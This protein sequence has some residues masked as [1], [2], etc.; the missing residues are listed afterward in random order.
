MKKSI[1]LI[2]LIIVLVSRITWGQTSKEWFA[3]CLEY[4]KV[5]NYDDSIE[6]F[7]KV[8]SIDPNH[9]RSHY[10]L[11]Y[12]YIKMKMFDE[13]IKEFMKMPLSS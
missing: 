10:N 12:L 13:A 3:I 5:N 8:V 6:C 4:M 9:E 2:A 1:F 11:G 7:K